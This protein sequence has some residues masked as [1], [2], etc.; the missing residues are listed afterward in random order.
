MTTPLLDKTVIGLL[1]KPA[2]GKG[3]IA[4]ILQE[5]LGAGRVT[6]CSSGQLL[7]EMADLLDLPKTRDNLQRLPVIIDQEFGRGTI[8][9]AMGKRLGAQ[10]TEVVIWDGVR[11]PTDQEL[12]RTASKHLII[13]VFAPQVVRYGR[14]RARGEKPGETE[15][16]LGRFLQ[17]DSAPTEAQVENI[18]TYADLIIQNDEN[19]TLE[20]LRTIVR[21]FLDAHL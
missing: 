8:S 19:C 21:K 5:E 2:S 6:R 7:S 20:D 17:E 9:R 16:T 14:A 18:G 11:W 12:I 4:Q 13:Y 3:T 15:M 1:G 10:E